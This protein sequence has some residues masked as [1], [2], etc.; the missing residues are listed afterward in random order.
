MVF[1]TND[2]KWNLGLYFN[3]NAYQGDLGN[4]FFDFSE[5]WKDEGGWN[6]SITIFISNI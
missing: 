6:F 2:N 3:L 1:Q 5:I 4:V